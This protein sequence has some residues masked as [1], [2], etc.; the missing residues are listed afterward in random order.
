MKSKKFFGIFHEFGIR[1]IWIITILAMADVLAMTLPFYLKNVFPNIH[2]ELGV[3]EWQLTKVTAIYGY[4]SLATYLLGG[5]LADKVSLRLLLVLGLGAIG[6]VGIWYGFIPFM[7]NESSNKFLQLIII[8]LIWGFAT[9]FIFWAPLWK[10][11]SEQGNSKQQG[12]VNGI[13]G[14]INGLF[15][16]LII[17]LAYGTY[18]ALRGTN[19]AFPVLAWIISGAALGVCFLIIIFIKSQEKKVVEETKKTSIFSS[20]FDVLK[21]YRIW[22]VSML[23]LGVYM[24]QTGLSFFIPYLSN[25]LKITS[26][27]VFVLGLM[28]TYLLRFATSTFAGR[29]ADKS[30]KYILFLVIGLIVNTIVVTAAILVPGFNDNFEQLNAGYQIFVQI[31]VSI[32]FLVLGISSWCLVTN[33]WA[34]INEINVSHNSYATAVGFISFLAFSPDA[35]FF[36]IA[37]IVQ[38]NYYVIVNDAKQTSQTG[39][40]IILFII[41]IFSAIGFLSG[42]FLLINKK[43]DLL[44]LKAERKNKVVKSINI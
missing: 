41:I 19:Y 20:L 40:Q 44:K 9:N 8:F 16:T 39:N 26:G 33:R 12:T 43:R 4:V 15:G 22:L 30:K 2:L 6:V 27:I 1:K 31:F 13:L 32:A 11:L 42:I 3:E 17:G 37:S 35:W 24:F 38:E 10:L 14:S 5:W 29:W 21:N 36:H 23:I 7:N 28:R 25:T 18:Y 34:T